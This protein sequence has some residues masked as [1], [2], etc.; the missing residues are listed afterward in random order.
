MRTSKAWLATAVALPCALA[1]GSCNFNAAVVVNLPRWKADEKSIVFFGAR[2]QGACSGDPS[3]LTL[4]FLLRDD[5]DNGIEEGSRLRIGERTIKLTTQSTT[6]EAPTLVVGDVAVSLGG[7]A[8]DPD[9]GAG[10]PDA[11]VGPYA[12]HAT[13]LRYVPF[14]SGG[15]SDRRD[16]LAAALLLDNGDDVQND[17]EEGVRLDGATAFADGFLCIQLGE[18]RC[19][20]GQTELEVLELSDSVV[21]ALA[22][23]LTDPAA[24]RT[25]L[26][27][28]RD[29]ARARGDG[30]VYDGLAK[31]A[32]EVRTEAGTLGSTAA[33]GALVLL[34]RDGRNES[35]A[36]L[37]GALA[38]VGDPPVYVAAREETAELRRIA[39]E[40]GGLLRPVA[41]SAEYR[42]AFMDIRDALRGR[43]EVDVDVSGLGDLAPGDHEIVGTLEVTVGGVTG[44]TDIR[45]T[46][47]VP[48]A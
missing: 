46:I 48:G 2:P 47:T 18:D 13:A 28:L 26:D 34:T 30:P 9:G 10:D 27:L 3:Q 11:G 1:L 41:A 43:F 40:S 19:P 6:G 7:V 16:P 25:K 21:T 36:T 44:T 20:F 37:D 22:P 45:F 15:R 5:R 35:K 29:S 17:D 8:G 31:G 39:C 12:V 24:V 38:A 42:D 4:A 14:T 32:P 23:F 33:R